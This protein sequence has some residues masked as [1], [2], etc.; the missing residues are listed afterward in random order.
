MKIAIVGDYSKYTGKPL[1]DFIYDSNKGNSINFVSSVEE[2]LS[3]L[4]SA[5]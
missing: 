2:A 4:D 3:K 1:K 5:E